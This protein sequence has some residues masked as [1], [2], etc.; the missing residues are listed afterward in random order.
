MKVDGHG[1]AKILSAKEI[2]LLFT[3]GLQS[4]RDRA[5]FG[6]L[7]YCGCRVSE[8]L[9]LTV[10]DIG[11]GIVTL[12]KRNTKGAIATRQIDI[13]PKLAALLEAYHKPAEGY[14]FPGRHG[15]GA[16]TRSAADLIL[17][18]ACEVMELEGVST[19]SF[20]RT[21]LTAMSNAGV[22]LRT[23]QSISGHTSLES[24]QRYL[25][26]KPEQKKA[27]IAALTFSD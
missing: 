26:V 10:A 2:D 25:E 4:D 16:M 3:H 13:H 23:I 12:R 9:A 11:G 6:I 14:L 21:A 22:P 7:L 8:A 1:Q 20:R 15:K 24:L 5:L 18:E 27:A 17:R 19:H